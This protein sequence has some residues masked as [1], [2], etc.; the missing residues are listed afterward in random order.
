M[1]SVTSD[2]GLT[3]LQ[4]EPTKLDSL[5]DLFFTNKPSL[6]SSL[7]NIPGIFTADEHEALV[8]DTTLRAQTVK[9]VPRKIQQ[10]GKAVWSKIRSDTQAFA[11]RFCDGAGDWSMDKQWDEIERHLADVIK[12]HVPSKIS[13][14]RTDQP[15]ITT[16]LR[17]KCRKKQRL[18]NKWKRLKAKGKPCDR[19]RKTY[20]NYHKSTNQHLQKSRVRYINNIL[21]DGMETNSNKPF[22]R[23]IKSQKT[24]STGVAPLKENGQVFSNPLKKA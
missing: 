15:W 22:W 24:E 7:D 19:A 12:K 1:I 16:E 5:L 4:R 23:Y 11:T 18:Y 9:S 20:K 8:A 3:Q 14:T 10:W 17:R 2:H 6:V 21:S 13:K